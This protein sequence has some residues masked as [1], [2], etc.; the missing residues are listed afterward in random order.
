MHQV[1]GIVVDE[2]MDARQWKMSWLSAYTL[3]GVA[4]NIEFKSIG[5]TEWMDVD[6]STVVAYT[7]TLAKGRRNPKLLRLGSEILK[8]MAKVLSLASMAEVNGDLVCAVCHADNDEDSL[9]CPGCSKWFHS[10]CAIGWDECASE[11]WWCPS[12]KND[13]PDDMEMLDCMDPA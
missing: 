2:N 11:A 12:C 1:Q 7:N 5:S 4:D 10:G 3:N 9:T 13:E 8:R 6:M